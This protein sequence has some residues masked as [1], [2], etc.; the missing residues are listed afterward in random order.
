MKRGS[1]Q[2]LIAKFNKLDFHD[3]VLTGLTVR[4]PRTRSNF[5]RIDFEFLDHSTRSGKIL[6]F[7]SCANFRFVADFDVLADN[8]NAG[9]T[10]A[11]AAKGDV[12]RMKKFVMTQ[13]SHWRTVYMPP[14][15]KDKPIRRKLRSI[16]GYI[17]FRLS[18]FGGTAEVL[19]KNYRLRR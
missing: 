8:L 7:Y 13:Q 11:S 17:L 18:F 1:K 9:N 2:A 12:T 16:K 6:S 3:D 14:M 15:P 5:T 4:P 19:S 10:W